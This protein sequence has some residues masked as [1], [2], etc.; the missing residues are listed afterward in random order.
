MEIKYAMITLKTTDYPMYRQ[1][2][3]GSTNLR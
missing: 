3:D 2:T 1:M